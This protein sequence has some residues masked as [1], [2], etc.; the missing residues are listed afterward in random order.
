MASS[1]YLT[2]RSDRDENDDYN[3]DDDNDV[4]DNVSCDHGGGDDDDDGDDN[5]SDAE[6]YVV[7]VNDDDDDFFV[8]WWLHLPWGCV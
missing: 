6:D 8:G 1:H 7:Y 4:L 2:C 3:I 5:E